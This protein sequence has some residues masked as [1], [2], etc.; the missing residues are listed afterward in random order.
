M[1]QS[2]RALPPPLPPPFPLLQQAEALGT[3][4]AL[5]TGVLS[6]G[7]ALQYQGSCSVQ[8]GER[9][10]QTLNR[11]RSLASEF[12]GGGVADSD[13]AAEALGRSA[14]VG[15]WRAWRSTTEIL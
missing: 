8:R 5:L 1:W 4:H 13:S 7:P 2:D 15:G 9:E 6:P 10:E 14:E 11:Y 3:S 12:F